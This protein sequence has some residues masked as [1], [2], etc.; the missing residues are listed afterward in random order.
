MIDIKL[1]REN[2]EFIKNKLSARNNDTNLINQILEKDSI[3]RKQLLEL[4]QHRA[5]RN[6]VTE[7]I[8]KNPPNKTDLIKEMQTLKQKIKEAEEIV[9]K[10]ENNEDES[11][12][13]LLLMLP[14]LPDDSVPVGKSAEENQVVK[15]IGEIKKFDFEP[16]D[17]QTIGE[18]LKILD[19]ETASKLSGSRFAML[20]SD[21]ARLE[22]ALINFMIDIHTQ[23]GYTE[24]FPPFIVDKKCLIGTGQLPKFEEELYKCLGKEKEIIAEM[25]KRSEHVLICGEKKGAINYSAYSSGNE[26]E[27]L[28][29]EYLIPTAEV[30]LTN[31]HREEI[32]DENQLTIKYVAYTACFRKEAGSYGK[33]TRGLIRNHQ[34]NKIELVKFTKPEDSMSELEGMVEDAG[35]VLSQLGLTYRIVKL[36]TADI[37]FSSSK[38]YDL[39]VWMPGEKKWREISSVSNCKDFQARRINCKYRKEK[40]LEYVHTLNGSGVAVG[41]TFAAILENFQNKDGSINIPQNLIKYFGKEKIGG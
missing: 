13:Q 36:C 37:G 8:S 34:F 14:N 28:G 27:Q 5:K 7:A 33:D 39:E 6:K 19:F 4:E 9:R 25:Q 23:R 22:R 2:P 30:P 16:L 31:M 24:I 32:L 21:G 29:D 41:R 18:G 3:Y 12:Q 1:I 11:I 10:Y 35:Q 40:K 20:K 26:G 38:T 17:H 15:Q